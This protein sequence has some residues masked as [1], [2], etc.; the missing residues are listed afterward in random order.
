MRTKMNPLVATLLAAFGHAALNPGP[1][2]RGGTP[3]KPAAKSGAGQYS[4]G[5]AKQ[6]NR[7]RRDA[8]ERKKTHPLRDAHGA[9]TLTGTTVEFIDIKPDSRH[10]EL[11]GS[12]GPDG[13]TRTARRIW[14]AG[15]SAQRGY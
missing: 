11:G 8:M 12:S 15:I 4:R 6:F 10:Y 5:L 7:Q 3:A 13:F 14:L 2:F 1:A 9:L